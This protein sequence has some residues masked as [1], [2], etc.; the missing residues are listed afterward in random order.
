MAPIIGPEWP[1]T[2]WTPDLMCD[3]FES[4][5]NGARLRDVAEDYGVCA[6]R[7]SQVLRKAAHMMLHPSRL[8]EEYPAHFNSVKEWRA[9]KD[10]WVRRIAKFRNVSPETSATKFN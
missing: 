9:N 1:G 7:M 5:L 4:I 8:D 10:F 3:A 6:E 2:R